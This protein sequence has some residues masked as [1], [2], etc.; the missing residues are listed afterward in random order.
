MSDRIEVIHA[1]G[2]DLVLKPI[3]EVFNAVVDPSVLAG[4]FVSAGSGPL[5]EGLTIE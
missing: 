5:E 4:F 1:R 3:E 2:K